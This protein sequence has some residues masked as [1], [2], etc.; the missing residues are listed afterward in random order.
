MIEEGDAV[1]EEPEGAKVG[2]EGGWGL[3]IVVHGGKGS[4]DGEFI[5]AMEEMSSREC[6]RAGT[7]DLIVVTWSVS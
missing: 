5:N 7:R 6:G 4:S 1:V 2:T 3:E